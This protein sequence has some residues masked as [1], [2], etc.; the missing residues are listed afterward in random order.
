MSHLVLARDLYPER[1]PGDEPEELE[2]VPWKLDA[3]HELIRS[4]KPYYTQQIELLAGQIEEQQKNG[5]RDPVAHADPVLAR[6]RAAARTEQMKGHVDSPL[7]LAG[8]LEARAPAFLRPA[9]G[10]IVAVPPSACQSGSRGRACIF[11][12]AAPMAS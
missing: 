7:R 1:L 11:D 8:V 12:E 3:L 2:V 10:L 5:G 9:P 6:Q 4:A